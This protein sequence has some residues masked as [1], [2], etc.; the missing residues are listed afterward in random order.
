ML[1]DNDILNELL[2]P[3]ESERNAAPRKRKMQSF[4]IASMIDTDTS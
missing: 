2:C 3:N 1:S 4:T